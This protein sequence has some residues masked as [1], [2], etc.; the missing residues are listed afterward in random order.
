MTDANGQFLVEDDELLASVLVESLRHYNE[1][2]VPLRSIAVQEVPFIPPTQSIVEDEVPQQSIGTNSVNK[3]SRVA[4]PLVIDLCQSP[5]KTAVVQSR[6]SHF[7]TKPKSDKICDEKTNSVPE[8][9]TNTLCIETNSLP[10]QNDVSIISSQAIFYKEPDANGFHLSSGSHYVYPSNFPVREYQMAIIKTALFHNTLVSLPTGMGKTFI[11]AVVMYNFYRWYPMGKVIFMAP[12]RPLVAQQIEACHSIMGIPRDMTFEMTGNIPPEQRYL[13]WNKY[14]VFFLTPQVLAN[15]LSLN[16]CPSDTFRC[17]IVDEA[18]RAT[19]DYAYVQVLK[20]LAEENRVIRIVGLSATPGTN[21]DAVTEVIQNLSISKLEFR[22]DES[23]DVAKY[24]NK[25]DVECIPV[26]L[27]NSI[28]E[29]RTQF[30]KIYDKYLRR[31]KQYHA[32]N[33]NVA[34]LTKFQILSAKQ[35]FVTSNIAREMPKSLV[36]CLI[37]DFTICMS[38]AYALELLT[39]YGVKVFYLQSL[40]IKENHKCLSNDADFQNLLHSIN[41]ELNSQDLVWSHPKLFELKKI[42]QNYF[43]NTNVEASSKIIIFCQYRLVVVEVFELLKTFG[44]SVKPVMFVG[45]SL[46]EKGGLPQKKQ[47]EVMSRFKSG[48]FNVLIATSVAEEGLDIGEVDLIICLEANKSPIKFVQRLGRTGRKR[49]GKCITLLTEGKEQIK[50]NSSVSSSKTLV[51]KM[52][53]SKVLLSKLA[54]NGPRLVPKHIHPKC[55]MIHVKKPEELFPE[56]KKLKG[57]KKG[58][59]NITRY[60]EP[61]DGQ[62][63]VDEVGEDGLDVFQNNIDKPKRRSKK[64]KTVELDTNDNDCR[65]VVGLSNAKNTNVDCEHNLNDNDN[66]NT[67]DINAHGEMDRT[68]DCFVEEEKLFNEWLQSCVQTKAIVMNSPFLELLNLFTDHDQCD[69]ELF[70]SEPTNN[71]FMEQTNVGQMLKG[72]PVSEERMIRVNDQPKRNADRSFRLSDNVRPGCS[73]VASTSAVRDINGYT[74]NADLEDISKEHINQTINMQPIGMRSSA[75]YSSNHKTTTDENSH[76]GKL[77]FNNLFQSQQANRYTDNFTERNTDL[78]AKPLTIE[79]DDSNRSTELLHYEDDDSNRSTELLNYV[80]DD[81]SSATRTVVR[82]VDEDED[83]EVMGNLDFEELFKSQRADKFIEKYSEE[84]TTE[85]PKVNNLA[86]TCSKKTEMSHKGKI[87]YSVLFKSQRSN[88]YIEDFMVR[89]TESC[90]GPSNA[91]NK[92]VRHFNDE[93]NDDHSIA[94]I[95]KKAI[96]RDNDQDEDDEILGNIDFEKLYKSRKSDI[97]IGKEIAAGRQNVDGSIA[98]DGRKSPIVCGSGQKAGTSGCQSIGKIDYSVLFKSQRSNG[99]IEDFMI[100]NTGVRVPSAVDPDVLHN[101]DKDEDDEVMG[102]LDFEQLFK[103]QKLAMGMETGGSDRIS[104]KQPNVGRSMENGSRK[105]PIACGGGQKAKT[106]GRSGKVDYS[107]LFKSQRSDGYIED[108]AEKIVVKTANEKVGVA[109]RLLGSDVPQVLDL[110]ENDNDDDDVISIKSSPEFF[111]CKPPKKVVQMKLTGHV[112]ANRS[113]EIIDLLSPPPPRSSTPPLRSSPPPPR[114]SPPPP[115]SSG[116]AN[117]PSACRPIS[118]D[119]LQ[120]NGVATTR[121]GGNDLLQLLDDDDDMDFMFIDYN[122]EGNAAADVF[123]QKHPDG[124]VFAQKQRDGYGDTKFVAQKLTDDGGTKT[125]TRLPL[126]PVAPVAKPTIK[127]DVT[128]RVGHSTQSYDNGMMPFN[129]MKAARLVDRLKPGLSMKRSTTTAASKRPVD[130]GST[131]MASKRQ[132]DNGSTATASKLHV[133]NGS[134]ATTSKRQVDNGSTTPTFR[135]KFDNGS[136]AALAFKRKIQSPANDMSPIHPPNGPRRRPQFSQS[137]PKVS[138]HPKQRRREIDTA[139]ATTVTAASETVNSMLTSSSD[140]DAFVG[141]GRDKKTT[142]PPRRVK[143]KR[144]AKPKKKLL[145]IDDEAD[146][147]NCFGEGNILSTTS[148]ENDDDDD[149]EQND[150]DSSFIDDDYEKSDPSKSMTKQYLQSVKDQ[151][152]AR[153]VFK[154]PQLTGHHYNIDVYSQMDDRNMD[155]DYEEDS[156]CVEDASDLNNTSSTTNTSAHRTSD[157]RPSKPPPSRKRKRIMSPQSTDSS[158]SSDDL[159]FPRK[160]GKVKTSL[161]FS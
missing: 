45:Q 12:T 6:L 130:N 106:V 55:L 103:S 129:I 141:H 38:L 17:I 133:D 61:N 122:S 22:T 105:S 34:N 87:D 120:T 145:F 101:D 73:Q 142:S 46:K 3:L 123:T 27:T 54:P 39:I 13:A 80:D 16:K 154:I 111:S 116:T 50:Y 40:E 43:G 9:Q 109:D 146:V 2:E 81:N 26:K 72:L 83:D 89:D 19:K 42:V 86:V 93:V 36:G 77:D 102:N 113:C 121:V 67:P 33:G 71:M 137:T 85:K 108:Y 92:V 79:D 91:D 1:V 49:S 97:C 63:E 51:M 82:D 23:P 64:R 99:Y 30:L 90:I 24:T 151:A 41:N 107:A 157:E 149:D 59:E 144:R 112:R 10:I 35:K 115:R 88:G 100:R 4:P 152:N 94:D 117:M 25:K 28:L 58:V 69:N 155:N 18:H 135:R 128:K 48:D 126:P 84:I 125:E 74:K 95:E 62:N 148:S 15:D 147:S 139:A 136:M 66:F 143:K 160:R 138:T 118:E 131:S 110:D 53:K 44:S 20:H 124:D 158:D 75:I 47:L 98:N 159:L 140:S 32:L 114:S 104:A 56:K 96:V 153:G 7:F 14:R 60:V 132:V 21:I 134:T 5:K 150:F 8:N 11:A 78:L 65:E 37:N 68:L 127:D 29:I 161:D 70:N 52:L 31:L 57:K 76:L 119:R 156:F